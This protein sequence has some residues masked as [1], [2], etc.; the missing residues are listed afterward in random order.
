MDVSFGLEW[1][2]RIEIYGCKAVS[3]L[4]LLLSSL[5]AVYTVT[6]PYKLC[7]CLY[8]HQSSVLSSNPPSSLLCGIQ[9]LEA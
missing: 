4:I 9:A 6:F 2:C 8:V 1:A 7:V 5:S 3:K